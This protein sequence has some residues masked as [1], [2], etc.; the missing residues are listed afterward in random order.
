MKHPTHRPVS[1]AWSVLRLGEVCLDGFIFIF[2]FLV[3]LYGL[4]GLIDNQRIH[5][6]ASPQIYATYKPTQDHSMSFEKLQKKNPD[7]IA[8]LQ[9]YGTGIDYPLVQG[10]DDEEYLNKAPDGSDCLSG[11]LFVHCANAPDFSDFNTIVYGHHMEDHKMFGDID[12]FV[13]PKFFQAH[14]YG[15]LYYGGQNHGVEIIACLITDAYDSSIYR[16]VSDDADGYMK[17]IK[18]CAVCQRK[19]KSTDHLIVLS[20][21]ADGQTNQRRLLVARITDQTYKNHFRSKT[22]SLD[23]P[24]RLPYWP[25]IGLAA[26]GMIWYKKSGR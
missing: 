13:Q 23:I 7:V 5:A 22:P 6:Q 2:F 17:R 9:I 14:R 19:I 12:L 15:N 16:V 4:Y 18:E 21:C 11:S 1:L 3:G 10:K 25:I 8:W 24:A 20:T 26:V